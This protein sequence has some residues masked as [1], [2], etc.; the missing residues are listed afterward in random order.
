M[1]VTGEGKEGGKGANPDDGW[2]TGDATWLGDVGTGTVV[3][4]LA[5]GGGT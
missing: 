4:A 2:G 5:G 1:D 3:R